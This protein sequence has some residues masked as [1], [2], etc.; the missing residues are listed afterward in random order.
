MEK[1]KEQFIREMEMEKRRES[2]YHLLN[3]LIES[4]VM[5]HGAGALPKGALKTL[6][7]LKG[8]TKRRLIGDRDGP[9]QRELDTV[10]EREEEDIRMVVRC[11]IMEGTNRGRRDFEVCVRYGFVDRSWNMELKWRVDGNGMFTALS[12]DRD[13]VSRTNPMAD[14]MAKVTGNYVDMMQLD[15]QSGNEWK[16]DPVCGL[17]P[18][19]SYQMCMQ[20]EPMEGTVNE[21][22]TVLYFEKNHKEE[23]D[24]KYLM[25]LEQSAVRFSDDRVWNEI[26]TITFPG[27]QWTEKCNHL[28]IAS[29]CIQ[30]FNGSVSRGS[31]QFVSTRE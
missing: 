10:G 23:G 15:V 8:Q 12:I 30:R 11:K 31:I 24:H 7:Q 18:Y 4:A 17:I 2:A 21:L 6:A 26:N 14:D 22:D 29:V 16:D 27:Q 1:M 28:S 25:E 13:E 20:Q 5:D 9:F 19:S 3:K